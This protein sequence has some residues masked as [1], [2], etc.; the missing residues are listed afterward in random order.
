MGGVGGKSLEAVSGSSPSFATVFLRNSPL[1]FRPQ[2][3]FLDGV[4]W[5]SIFEESPNGVV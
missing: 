1:F 5:A 3:L 4:I 2:C